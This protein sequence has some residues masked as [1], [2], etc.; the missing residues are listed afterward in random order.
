M[1]VKLSQAEKIRVLNGEDV[2]SI[3]QRILKRENKIDRNKEHFWTIGLNAGNQLLYV[4]LISLGTSRMAL[5]EPM[6]VFRVAILKGAVRLILVHNHPSGTLKPTDADKTVTDRLL[7]VGKIIDIEVIDHLIITEESYY[8]FAGNGV[9]EEL[10]RS[11][12]YVPDYQLKAQLRK[13]VEV[14]V[15][16]ERDKEI[17]RQM[18]AKGFTNEQIAEITGLSVKSIEKLK[19]SNE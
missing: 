19:V 16:Q 9:L 8:S 14:T 5:A 17:A 15:K 4:E 7:Q 11:T 6:Q 10:K 18:K 1:N 2:Y 13:E 3:M 12:Q